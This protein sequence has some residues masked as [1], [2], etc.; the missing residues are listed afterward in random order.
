[1]ITAEQA[2]E[3]IKLLQSLDTTGWVVILLLGGLVGV[4]ISKG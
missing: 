2:A 3:I 1:M 4:T